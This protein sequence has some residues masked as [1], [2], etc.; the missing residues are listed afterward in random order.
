MSIYWNV[1]HLVQAFET[2][3]SKIL[4]S[5]SLVGFWTKIKHNVKCVLAPPSGMLKKKRICAHKF[6][7]ARSLNSKLQDVLFIEVGDAVGSNTGPDEQL[8]LSN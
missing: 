1:K 7:G 3:S 4:V 2:C 5:L 8:G 6:K